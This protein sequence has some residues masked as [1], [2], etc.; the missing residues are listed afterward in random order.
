MELCDQNHPACKPSVVT[1]R[2]LINCKSRHVE[3]TQEHQPYCT[4]SY[5][6]G[7]QRPEEIVEDDLL[8]QSLPATIED[9]IACTL[10]LGYKYLWI[11]RYCI[12]QRQHSEKIQEIGRMDE[13]YSGAEFGLFATFGED[14]HAG[15]PGMSVSRKRQ[16]KC[17]VGKHA[18]VE[19]LWDP[20]T[21][22]AL[23]KWAQRGWTYQE[24][25]LSKRRLFFTQS[26]IYFECNKHYHIE[27]GQDSVSHDNGLETQLASWDNPILPPIYSHIQ[28]Y[29]TRQL[30]Y[31]SD[32]LKAMLGIFHH[33]ERS[34]NPVHH[35]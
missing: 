27:G 7:R 11:D 6:W 31:P 2:R 15:L 12:S 21:K 20:K 26:G 3:R 23:S 5:V 8:P 32:S 17:Q 24:L 28:A 10:A 1:P 30:T 9:A 29:T 19:K 16:P 35:Y 34:Q 18:L 22:I 14:T 25:L 4:L 13:I 33:L